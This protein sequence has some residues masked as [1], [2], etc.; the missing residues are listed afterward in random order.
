MNWSRLRIA[1][2][3]RCV[4]ALALTILP[5]AP[6]TAEARNPAVEQSTFDSKN[7][8]VLPVRG[9]V[10]MLVGAGCN[11]TVQVG[12]QYVIVVDAGLPEF[13]GEVIDTIRK[14]TRLPIM[15]VLN[16]SSDPDHSGG[17][18]KFYQAGWSLPNPD[19]VDLVP[20]TEVSKTHLI[21]PPGASILASLNTL[22][23]IDVS[24]AIKNDA[25][26]YGKEGLKLYNKEPVVFYH[27]GKAHTDGDSMVFFRVSDV[28]S[29]GDIFTTTSYPVIESENGGSVQ[30][31]IDA[32]NDLI[33]ILVPKYGEEGGTYVIPGHGHLSDRADVVNYR[34]MVTIIN[35]RIQEMVKN[36]MTLEQVKAARPTLDYDG[37][38]GADGGRKFT[39]V[40]YHE[41]AKDTKRPRTK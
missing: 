4:L 14:L 11:I 3:S 38:Y 8:H 39:E 7:I 41:L 27:L 16:T 17:D 15:F 12:E 2:V 30:G 13:A 40:V 34:D 6:G 26:S 28:V 36:G 10:Y 35:G 23:R 32:L 21:L 31:F 19:R 5:G 9:N 18:A 24:T 37:I 22:N 20:R 33:E 1:D 25:V 29:A